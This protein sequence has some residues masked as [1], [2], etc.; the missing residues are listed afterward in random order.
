MSIILLFWVL[1][2]NPLQ[3]APAGPTEKPKTISSFTDVD[4]ADGNFVY[5]EYITKRGFITGFPDGTFHP[6]EGLTRAQAAVVIARAAGLETPAVDATPFNDLEASHWAASSITAAARAGYIAGFPDGS[7]R[8][9]E[10]LTRVQGITLIMNLCTQSERAALPQLEDVTSD[11]WAA[12]AI[13]TALAL[14]M[15]GRSSD[16]SKVYPDAIMTRG[17]MARALS[18]L[19]T[20]DPGLY[21]TPLNGTLCEIKGTVTLTRSGKTWSV[22]QDIVIKEGDTI[23]TGSNGQARI[24]YPDGSGTM[25]EKNTQV[26]V[27]TAQG[28]NYIKKDGS[29]GN[30]VDYLKLDLQKGMLLGAL[31]TKAQPSADETA[32]LHKNQVAA[33]DS[34]NYLAANTASNQKWYQTAQSKKVKVEVDMPWGVAAIRGTFVM[35]T[36]NPDGSCRVSCLTGNAEVTG[37]SG[38]P[39]AIGGG[40]STGISD[41][42]GQAS[43]ASGMTEEDKQQFARSDIQ[44]WVVDTALQIDLSQEAQPVTVIVDI[45]DPESGQIEENAQ[46]TQ[47]QLIAAVVETIV[48]ALQNSGIELQ[49]EVRENLTQQL[50]D[51]GLP[52][53]GIPNNSKEPPAPQTPTPGRPDDDD[54]DRGRNTG[55]LLNQLSV[56]AGTLSPAFDSSVTNY[57]VTVDNNVTIITVKAVAASSSAKIIINNQEF[58][59]GTAEKAIQ[60]QEGI[61]TVVIKVTNGTAST[62]YTLT[63]TRTPKVV[64]GTIESPADKAAVDSL[65]LVRGTTDGNG[66]TVTGVGLFI[67]N[68]TLSKWIKPIY[69]P[70]YDPDNET[71]NEVYTGKSFVHNRSEACLLY[72]MSNQSDDFSNWEIDLSSLK[73]AN[74]YDYVMYLRVYLKDQDTGEQVIK[75]DQDVVVFSTNPRTDV[76]SDKSEVPLEEE[77]YIYYNNLWIELI[78]RDQN[79]VNIEGLEA[80]QFCAV[81]DDGVLPVTVSFAQ[82]PFNAFCEDGDYYVNFFGSGTQVISS[83]KVGGVEILDAPITIDFGKSAV[84]EGYV[85]VEEDGSVKTPLSEV[86]VSAA[87]DY[88][89]PQE[90]ISTAITDKYG[91]YSLNVPFYDYYR[92]KYDLPGYSAPYQEVEVP[93]VEDPETFQEIE[94]DEVIMVRDDT[95]PTAILSLPCEDGIS[96]QAVDGPLSDESWYSIYNLIRDNPDYWNSDPDYPDNLNISDICLD[97]TEMLRGSELVILQPFCSKKEKALK[98]FKNY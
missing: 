59:G 68:E 81:I 2:P 79:D 26:T 41:E 40:Q 39:V 13:A 3:G 24:T 72:P 6:K 31:A 58:N 60:L 73:L 91:R 61:N 70:V 1:S 77:P 23:Q 84:V 66:Y 67:W 74:G 45:P 10:Q 22:S 63:I 43:M 28:R 96:L 47:E 14:E 7:F 21:S 38:S 98:P 85:Y 88:E 75:E 80:D 97:G 94:I 55:A 17:S 48:N 56:S 20:R 86:E 78:I 33:L 25:L 29:P 49:P 51:L 87:L 95:G 76:D 12:P 62:T 11:H 52:T 16:G 64:Y 89:Y 42:G 34:F 50:R 37:N 19:L 27:K 30:A 36:I 4:S 46:P 82:P 53:S 65:G 44:A 71:G 54:N 15:V 18:I 35:V 57:S 92:I 5:I 93:W 83:L 69:N 90:V 9:D 8:A 32:G